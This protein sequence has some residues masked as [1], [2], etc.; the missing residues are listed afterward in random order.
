[1]RMRCK[2]SENFCR[3]LLIEKLVI[4]YVVVLIVIIVHK[5]SKIIEFN[6]SSASVVTGSLLASNIKG[7]L[8]ISVS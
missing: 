1:M 8:L 6:F 7:V 3:Q 2:G 5:P 4:H